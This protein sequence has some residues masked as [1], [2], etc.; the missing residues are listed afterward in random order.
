MSENHQ[1]APRRSADERS[2]KVYQSWQTL[3]K[4][5]PLW[6]SDTMMEIWYRASIRV[7]R[8]AARGVPGISR[9]EPVRILSGEAC[10]L[11]NYLS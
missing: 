1:V 6:L 8:E 10:G 7:V 11:E 3:D 2:P 9:P 4:E 5:T